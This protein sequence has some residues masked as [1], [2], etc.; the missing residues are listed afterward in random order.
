MSMPFNQI[1]RGEM[2][3]MPR[4]KTIN[5]HTGK[6][7][8]YRGRNV[9]NWVLINDEKEFGITVHYM[10]N[11]IDTGDII[12]QSSY[13]IT[14]NDTYETL[15]KQAYTGCTDVL[16]EAVKK[17]QDGTA[18]RINQDSIDKIGMYCGMRTLEEVE[19]AAAVSIGAEKH[20]DCQEKYCC[21]T[22]Y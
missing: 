10:D 9:L 18:V 4:L 16:Y 19:E 20:G 7:P 5:C 14:D 6:L 12:L 15:L 11:G 21:K 17:I 1:F 3:H 2:I 22:E 13:P 8:F